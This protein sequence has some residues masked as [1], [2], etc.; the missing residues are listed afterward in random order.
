MTYLLLCVLAF[1]LLSLHRREWIVLCVMTL[2]NFAITCVYDNTDQVLYQLVPI[3]TFA[4]AGA[5]C[6]F[7]TNLGF[8]QA[9]VLL[10]TLVAYAALAFDVSQ[11]RHILIY[12]NYEAVIYG[13]VGC[14][15]A[16]IF[17]ALR[18]AYRHL[19]S[20]GRTWLADLSRVAGS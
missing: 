6:L 1:A 16:A 18:S 5:L 10:V 12:N 11:G 15:F 4:G 3:V 2:C 9:A 7:K 13:L 17:P 19:D 8:Y 14:Q 20:S